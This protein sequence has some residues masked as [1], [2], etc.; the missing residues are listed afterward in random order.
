MW[1][2]AEKKLSKDKHIGPLIKKFGPCGLKKQPKTKYFE[3]LVRDITGQQLSVK[4]ASTIFG[5]LKE[6]LGGRVT[7]EAIIRKRKSTLRS[8]GLSNA[9]SAYIKDLAKHVKNKELE[10]NRLD[11]LTD[12][13]VMEELIAVKG[14]GKWTAE[15]FLM[16]TLARPDVFPVDDLGIRKGMLKLLKRKSMSESAMEKFAAQWAPYRTV[17]SWYIWEL[18]DNK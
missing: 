17:A 7:P 4:A 2:E 13:K 5:R 14:I 12:E 10:I 3:Y 6:K 1:S 15:M 9:K 11:D 8:C 16:F 18:L